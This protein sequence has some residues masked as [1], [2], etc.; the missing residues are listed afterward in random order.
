MMRSI[1]PSS[2]QALRSCDS[3]SAP[4]SSSTS[5]SACPGCRRRSSGSG[6]P[7]SPRVVLYQSGAVVNSSASAATNTTQSAEPEPCEGHARPRDGALGASRSPA[8]PPRARRSGRCA[9]RVRGAARR[10]WRS[11]R[12]PRCRAWLPRRPRAPTRARS[13]SRACSATRIR[14]STTASR[15][16]SVVSDSCASGTAGTRWVA[17]TTGIA[18][19]ASATTREHDVEG[20]ERL[21]ARARA[22]LVRV[23]R[24]EQRHEQHQSRDAGGPLARTQPSQIHAAGAYRRG[25]LPAPPPRARARAGDGGRDGAPRP[26]GAAGARLLGGGLTA[27]RQVRAAEL[28]G[29]K[30]AS[31]RGLARWGLPANDGAATRTLAAPGALRRRGRGRPSGCSRAASR[32]SSARRRRAP[33]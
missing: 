16:T 12:Q 24:Q 11:A 25:P 10:A 23:P 21:P 6:E 29:P 4:A 8:A 26:G 5:R 15:P 14:T 2:R 18:S 28:C 3:A 9:G 22:R 32:A 27:V 17:V 19:A 30:A 13:P 1:R 7:P 31:R 33:G 20:A